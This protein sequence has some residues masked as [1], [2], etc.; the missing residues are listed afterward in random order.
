[1]MFVLDEAD[2]MLDMGFLPSIRRVIGL[3]P[4]RRHSLMFSAT[5]SKEIERLATSLLDDPAEVS[6]APQNA[7]ADLVEHRIHPVDSGRKRA[8]LK[9]LIH[10]GGWTQV[11]VFTRTKHGANR[12]AIGRAHV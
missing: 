2:R 10:D 5:F 4:A 8:L 11:L 7:P 6:V 12:L 9:R 3:L 1:E